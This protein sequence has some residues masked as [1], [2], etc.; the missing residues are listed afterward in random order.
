MLGVAAV[1]Y[2]AVIAGWVIYCEAPPLEVTLKPHARLFL[3][4]LALVPL[5]L[6]LPRG[7][8]AA[9]LASARVPLA[10]VLVPFEAVWLV[11]VA[12]K[13]L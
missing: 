12:G 6:S 2:M 3:P 4:L 7:R 1:T 11:A 10:L 8:L 9:R 13:M 5:A